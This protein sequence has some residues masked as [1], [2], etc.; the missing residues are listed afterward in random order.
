[1]RILITGAAGNI[2][3]QMVDELEGSHEL[4]LIDRLAIPGRNVVVA[5]L[6]RPPGGTLIQRARLGRRARWDRAFA[7]VDALLHL[8]AQ[9]NPRGSWEDMLRHNVQATVNVLQAAVQ[10]DVKH[11]VFASSHHAVL[12]LERERA[13]GSGRPRE[14]IGSDAPARPLSPYGL[15]KAVGELCGQMLVDQARLRSFIAVRIG[16]WEPAPPEDER[17][18]IWLGASDGRSLLRRCLEADLTGF[19]VVY[20]T[21]AQ[22]ES[23]YDLSYTARVL[24]WS[25]GQLP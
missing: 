13:S 15:S 22:P 1:M 8:A 20:G 14:K 23:P 18:L 16:A 21:S 10:A 24:D 3:R 19:H 2:G 25:P 17:R 7:R 9:G 4:V 6:S 12:Q 11:V 5:D